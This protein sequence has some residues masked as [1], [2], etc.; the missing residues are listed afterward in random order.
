MALIKNN[1]R[2]FGIDR[3]EGEWHLHPHG[4]VA[5][6][7]SLAQGME[8]KPLLTFLRR[9]EMILLEHDLV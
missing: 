3:E 9:V 6:H 2:I 7:E 5:A 4:D 1:Q 8:P